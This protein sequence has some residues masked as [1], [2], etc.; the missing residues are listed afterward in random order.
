LLLFQRTGVQFITP[1]SGGS[2]PPVTPAPGNLMSSFLFCGQL[3]PPITYTYIKDKNKSKRKK[4]KEE[5]VG[6]GP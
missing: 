5:R 3:P 1:T 2:Q 6:E 4:K